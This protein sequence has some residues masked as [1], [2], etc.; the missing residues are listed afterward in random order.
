MVTAQR[1]AFRKDIQYLRALAIA[2]V[3]LFHLNP[4]VFPNGYLGVDVFFVI[5][6]FF[7]SILI[8]DISTFTDYKSYLRKRFLRLYPPLVITSCCAIFVGY[9]LLWSS[10]FSKLASK[11]LFSIA[12]LDNFSLMRDGGYFRVDSQ[13]DPFQHI[14]SLCV[15]MQY[16]VLLP[17]FFL[18]INRSFK[19]R[20]LLLFVILSLFV[21]LFLEHNSKWGLYPSGYFNPLLRFWEFGLGVWGFRFR[22]GYRVKVC[23]SIAL[24]LLVFSNFISQMFVPTFLAVLLTFGI[25]NSRQNESSPN[26]RRHL[27]KIALW[28]GG[29]SYEIYLIHWPLLAFPRLINTDISGFMIVV[30]FMVLI[31]LSIGLRQLTVF[32]RDSKSSVLITSG[33]SFALVCISVPISFSG[34]PSRFPQQ[35][36]AISP[37]N[38]DYLRMYDS[39]HCF[40][41]VQKNSSQIQSDCLENESNSVLI[42]GDSHAAHLLSGL[43]SIYNEKISLLAV[44]SCAPSTLETGSLCGRTSVLA[45]RAIDAGKFHTVVLSAAWDHESIIQVGALLRAIHPAQLNVLVIGPLPRWTK[46]LEVLF[47]VSGGGNL[48]FYSSTSLTKETAINDRELRRIAY[49]NGVPYLSLLGKLCNASGC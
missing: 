9:F 45:R 21:T 16:F 13:Y 6:G 12:S 34:I 30:Y 28:V 26:F 31:S 22:L 46:P 33:V 3:V 43:S 11:A 32:I 7:T 25:L 10:E 18:K 17:L 23:I 37:A 47:P 24:T 38:V 41:P 5:S 19:N 42:W 2:S 4:Q 39:G 15:E 8:K 1:V 44:S 40:N 20:V 29:M 14:W 27:Q 35:F 36:Q 49:L 48:P